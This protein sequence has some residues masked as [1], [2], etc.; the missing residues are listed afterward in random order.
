MHVGSNAPHYLSQVQCL[1]TSSARNPS[2]ES[3]L[4][5]TYRF[6]PSS[7]YVEDDSDRGGKLWPDMTRELNRSLGYQ[8][9][10][11]TLLLFDGSVGPDPRLSEPAL[12]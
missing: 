9:S 5:S 7:V 4:A 8:E 6:A 10:Q 2:A 12:P 1:F 11:T 3:S